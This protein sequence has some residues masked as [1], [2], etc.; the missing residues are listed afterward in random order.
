VCRAKKWNLINRRN[1]LL[2]LGSPVHEKKNL[3]LVLDL[4]LDCCTLSH[5]TVF[6]GKI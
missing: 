2:D 5:S 3:D 6:L 1:D 4:D